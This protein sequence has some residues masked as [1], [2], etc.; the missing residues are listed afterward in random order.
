MNLKP[1]IFMAVLSAFTFTA[2]AGQDTIFDS[3]DIGRIY[4]RAG[5]SPVM[6]VLT[7]GS[8]RDS[9]DLR[10]QSLWLLDEDIASDTFRKLSE[11]ML[12]TVNAPEYDGVGIAAPQVGIFVRAI[13]V[14]RF[15]KE[16]EPFEV[17]ANPEIVAYSDATTHTMEGCLSVPGR[18]GMVERPR[19]ITVQYIDPQTLEM[20]E[21]VV[22]GYTAVIFQHEIDHL[23]G[24][25]FIDKAEEANYD[26]PG[27]PAIMEE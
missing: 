14:M 21:E 22:E 24:I 12:A 2:A 16:G 18:Y 6:R 26:D 13:A 23:D 9:V 4:C 3:R 19:M 17:Y 25:L 10:L 8:L 27:E 15:D 7:T 20:R 1:L 5:E 11:R